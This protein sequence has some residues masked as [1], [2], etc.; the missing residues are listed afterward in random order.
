MAVKQTGNGEFQMKQKKNKEKDGIR[1][2]LHSRLIQHGLRLR[3]FGKKVENS[4]STSE[5][6]LKLYVESLGILQLI[7]A[8]V[9]LD[10]DQNQIM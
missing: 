6:W 9:D 8:N 3:D 1:F 7:K 5:G 4:E 10:T 2:L